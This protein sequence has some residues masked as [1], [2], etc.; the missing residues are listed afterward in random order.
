[1]LRAKWMMTAVCVVAVCGSVVQAKGP[2]RAWHKRA[3][4]T[5][6]VKHHGHVYAPIPHGAPIPLGAPPVDEIPDVIVPERI[7]QAPGIEDASALLDSARRRW[8]ERYERTVARRAEIRQDRAARLR[9]LAGRLDRS[10]SERNDTHA[11]LPAS[12]VQP[13]I[14]ADTP[15]RW[16]SGRR[17][18]RFDRTAP[19][20]IEVRRPIADRFEPRRQNAGPTFPS[21]APRFQPSSSV[22]PPTTSSDAE[23]DTRLSD[24]VRQ[25][26]SER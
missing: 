17:G 14:V 13:S 16:D 23:Q 1:M 4:A 8:S 7:P 18:D 9:A 6:S 25:W 2:R 24:R 21:D 19:R 26:W 10:A 22:T 11:D 5:K 12:A 3:K 15:G 20:S